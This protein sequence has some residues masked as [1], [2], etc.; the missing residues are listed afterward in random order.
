MMVA[1]NHT[2]PDWSFDTD[3]ATVEQ[4]IPHGEIEIA[5]LVQKDI[6]ERAKVGCK[7]YGELLKSNNGRNALWD[8]YQE[9]LDLCMYLRQKIEEE[10]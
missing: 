8:A 6:E 5:P 3:P 7:K 4:P 10:K 9:V 1:D 2:P